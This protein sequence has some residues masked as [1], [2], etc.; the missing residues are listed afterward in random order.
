MTTT[1]ITPTSTDVSLTFTLTSPLHHGAGSQGNSALLRTESVTQPDGRSVQV[2]FV[3]ANSIR[4]GLRDAL[5]WHLVTT[6]EVPRGTLS[7]A[8]VDL[9]WSGGAVSSTGARTNLELLRRIEDV[10]PA[11]SLMGFAAQSD[12]ITGT[13][14]VRNAEL[15]CRE[16]S[17]RLPSALRDHPLAQRRAAAYR[18]SEF[19]TRHDVTGGPVD[20]LLEISGDLT[21][22]PSTQMI[23]DIQ[24]LNAG[25]MLSGGVSLTPAATEDHRLVMEAALSLWAPGGTAGLAAKTAVGYGQATVDGIPDAAGESLRE[26]TERVAQDGERILALISEVADG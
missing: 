16:N 11:L 20:R 18:G 23:Y 7:K 15:V 25:S 3:S 9:L 22:A 5:A 8:A 14:R 1:T 10:Y 6:L 13:L 4:H 12:I 24:T 21:G 19:G 17:F 2:P 26:W